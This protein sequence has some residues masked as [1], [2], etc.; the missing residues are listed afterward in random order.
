MAADGV[1]V[2]AEDG[3]RTGPDAMVVSFAGAPGASAGD[4][5]WLAGEDDEGSEGGDEGRNEEGLDGA[6]V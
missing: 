5:S 3:A 2:S 4:W 1:F 6:W